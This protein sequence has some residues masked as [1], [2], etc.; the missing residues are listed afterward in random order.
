[1]I[2]RYLLII[3]LLCQSLTAYSACVPSGG[4]GSL[5]DETCA[6]SQVSLAVP[7][8]ARVSLLDAFNFG[9]FDY[10]TAPQASDDFCIW[11]NSSLF[12]MT[13]NSANSIGDGL[14]GLVGTNTTERIDYNVLWFYQAGN[15][16][17]SIDLTTQ[18]NI[19]QNQLALN[20]ISSSDCSINNTSIGIVVPLENLQDKPED[21]YSDTL[22]VTVS[23][24]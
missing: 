15:T 12:S 6:E 2:E 8:L 20:Q 5:L 13:V 24:Q 1:M 17:N 3:F 18:E 7:A 16:G 19:P 4:N 11:Y 10:I 9:E 14:F 23:V 22:T 21:S